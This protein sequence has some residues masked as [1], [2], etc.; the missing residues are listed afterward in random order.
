M[1]PGAFVRL[2][3]AVACAIREYPADPFLTLAAAGGHFAA[4]VRCRGPQISASLRYQA[5]VRLYD[6]YMA[7]D[8]QD[9]VRMRTWLEHG[10]RPRDIVG[11]ELAAERMV[12]ADGC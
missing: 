2:A 3:G 5:S 6:A 4:G 9:G 12:R 1:N 10:Y 7:S 8:R 11:E